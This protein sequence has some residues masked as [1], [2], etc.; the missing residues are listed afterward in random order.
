MAAGIKSTG[1]A[2]RVTLCSG[3]AAAGR[4]ALQASHPWDRDLRQEG[5]AISTRCEGQI[6]TAIKTREPRRAP[7]MGKEGLKGKAR[8]RIVKKPPAMMALWRL[9]Q[10]ACREHGGGVSDGGGDRGPARRL[11]CD[12]LALGHIL[13]SERLVEADIVVEALE[14]LGAR[15]TSPCSHL[16]RSCATGSSAQRVPT[17][18]PEQ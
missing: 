5:P 10:R 14:E 12:V 3:P 13:V 8:L 6:S 9:G 1:R 4:P 7:I 11:Q 15:A 2:Q 17:P 16:G 18:S